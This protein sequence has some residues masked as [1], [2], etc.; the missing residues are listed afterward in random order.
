[1]HRQ[2]FITLARMYALRCTQRLLRR[3]DC[4][5]VPDNAAPG[6]TAL[7]DWFVREYNVGRNRLLLCTS[8]ASLLTVLI[9]ARNLPHMGNRLAAAVRELLV[10]MDVPLAQIDSEIAAMGS[11]RIA[12]TN[13][14][15]VLGS[16]NDMVYMADAFLEGAV[17]PDGILAAELAMAEAPCGPIGYR[18][19]RDI[20]LALLGEAR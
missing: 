15:S 17:I 5:N 16:M 7:G 20:V 19:P 8:S 11:A 18:A 9:P 13:S 4:R 3:L 1:M 14:R 12:R 6:T 2:D 10:A